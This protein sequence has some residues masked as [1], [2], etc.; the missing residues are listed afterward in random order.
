MFSIRPRHT[1]SLTASP[2]DQL[3]ARQ[4]PAPF[5]GG[6]REI[7]LD[8]TFYC[9]GEQFYH[10]F[11]ISWQPNI[12]FTFLYVHYWRLSGRAQN[13]SPLQRFWFILQQHGSDTTPFRPLSAFWT[14]KAVPLALSSTTRRTSRSSRMKIYRSTT[15]CCFWA[16]LVKVSRRGPFGAVSGLTE[17]GKYVLLSSPEKRRFLP[18]V[19]Q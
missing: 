8:I 4:S 15:H 14:T 12:S 13:Q 1:V 3:N 5:T 2:H 9:V 10:I 7:S 17:L 11:D 18:N 6:Q 16:P 19:Y